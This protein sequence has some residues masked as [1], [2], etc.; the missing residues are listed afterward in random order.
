MYKCKIF[1]M[2]MKQKFTFSK[3]VKPLVAGLRTQLQP[4]KKCMPNNTQ[5]DTETD[6]RG[7]ITEL[8]VQ[9]PYRTTLSLPHPGALHQTTTASACAR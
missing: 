1:N 4:D 6:C 3:S 9:T 2:F 5:L 7:C 8:P